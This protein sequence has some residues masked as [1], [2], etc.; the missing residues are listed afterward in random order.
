MVQNHLQDQREQNQNIANPWLLT[1]A[2][3][4]PTCGNVLKVT[5]V[6]LTSDAEHQLLISA[7]AVLSLQ[8][9]G[10]QEDPM[11]TVT[12]RLGFPQRKQLHNLRS[13]CIQRLDLKFGFK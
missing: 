6:W 2:G 8:L 4:G 12:Q 5:K 7:A 11:P 10:R 9:V 1:E 13:P 3:G